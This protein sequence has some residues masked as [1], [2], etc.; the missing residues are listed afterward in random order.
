MRIVIDN[1]IILDALLERKPY[2]DLSAQ[3]MT[4]C[5]DANKG[6][7]TANSLTDIFYVL[8]KSI[9]AAGAKSAIRQLM[10]LLETISINEEDCINALSLPMDD[11]EDALV[12]ICARKAEA[13]YIV[14]RDEEFL[15]QTAPV[16]TISP[17]KLLERFK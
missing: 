1:N 2:F 10:E 11:F 3:V 16:T 12:A 6:Y 14:T 9:G 8:K 4:A 15:S 7:V 17:R 5:A 13:D